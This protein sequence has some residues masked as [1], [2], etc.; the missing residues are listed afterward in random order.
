MQERSPFIAGDLLRVQWLSNK[1]QNVVS[2]HDNN[3]CYLSRLPWGRNLDTA[4]LGFSGS[5]SQEGQSGDSRGCSH[6]QRASGVI[7]QLLECPHS[8][9]AGFP[10]SKRNQRGSRATSVTPDGLRASRRDLQHSSLEGQF[11]E[12]CRNINV[13]LSESW[14]V[15]WML[16]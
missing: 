11:P 1:T 15:G 7:L 9:S 10:Q 2:G 13:T 6:S 8:R 16:V 3:L 14:C 12:R 4:H 5:G